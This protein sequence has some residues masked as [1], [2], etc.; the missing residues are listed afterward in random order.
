MLN[1]ILR[2]RYCRENSCR[3]L[4]D[5]VFSCSLPALRFLLAPILLLLLSTQ[6]HLLIYWA[7]ART[8]H[9]YYYYISYHLSIMQVWDCE[10]AFSHAIW[11]NNKPFYYSF[12]TPHFP[13]QSASRRLPN[14]QKESY[15]TERQCQHWA[16]SLSSQTKKLTLCFSYII[17]VII[18]LDG[19]PSC[20][21]QNWWQ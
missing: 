14:R 17:I 21:Q 19:L 6:L 4:L 3:V 11:K 18:S 20:M 5:W 12:P 2:D 8:R 1:A 10:N 15:A 9:Y 7:R 13:L 16:S